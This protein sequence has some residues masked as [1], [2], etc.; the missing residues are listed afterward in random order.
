[1]NKWI[2]N[3][4][5]QTVYWLFFV[6]LVLVFSLFCYNYL[7][8]YAYRYP[9]IQNYRT[10]YLK[11]IPNILFLLLPLILMLIGLKKKKGIALLC[12]CAFL[13]VLP[14]VWLNS[15]IE[16]LSAPTFCS[17]TEDCANY[18]QY[19][20]AVEE[21]I[22]LNGQGYL[23]ETIPSEAKNVCYYYR[24]EHASTD[25]IYISVS[26]EYTEAELQKLQNQY[27]ADSWEIYEN[28]KRAVFL[29][30]KT[31]PGDIQ[32][33]LHAAIVLCETDNMVTHILT[34]DRG[35][36]DGSLS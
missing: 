32:P 23:P 16:I 22:H 33:Y 29:S 18:G 13:I 8:E 5:K 11:T 34:N 3:I 30:E 6:L 19:D 24:Y 12:G 31:A 36:V 20:R 25:T 15:T 26:W 17:Y 4:S 28:G 10:L 21:S 9:V 14:L 7:G 35:Q 2:K 27:N 1:M